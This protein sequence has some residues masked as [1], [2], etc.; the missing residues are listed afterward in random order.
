MIPFQGRAILWRWISHKRY[1]IQTQ[2]Q[3]NTN[4]DLHTPYSTVLLRMTLSDL[5]WLSK[6]FNDTKRH[7]VS[8]R[9][10]SFL[11]VQI[12]RSSDLKN[13][14]HLLSWICEIWFL[15]YGL[16]H[17]AILLPCAN[18]HW[19]W[20]VRSWVMIKDDFQ[21]GGCL[22]SWILKFYIFGHVTTRFKWAV[23]YRILPKSDDFSL[24]Y[25]D[26]TIFKMAD[27]CRI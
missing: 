9:Q 15:C 23:V 10:L 14:A 2:F 7:A 22:P 25:G 8:L 17:R 19:N 5:E 20:T 11:F 1:D 12:W 24:R 26:L 18:F 13:G 6:I 27:I 16:C 4:S 3:W 21:N